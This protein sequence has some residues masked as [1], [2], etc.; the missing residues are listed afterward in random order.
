MT[1]RTFLCFFHGLDASETTLQLDVVRSEGRTGD[2]AVYGKHGHVYPDSAGYLI[3]AHATPRRWGSIK[4]SLAFCRLT[5]DGDDEGC[6][7]LG[8][9]PTGAESEAIRDA[10]GVRKRR[11]LSEETKERARAVLASARSLYKS[12]FPA[13]ASI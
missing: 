12:G 6:F 10:L 5:Q 7:R 13:P 2:W 1:A 9:L 4:K 8:R 3:H 11:H